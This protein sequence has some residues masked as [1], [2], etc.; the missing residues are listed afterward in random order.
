MDIIE[1]D[2]KSFQYGFTKAQYNGTVHIKTS[3]DHKL[4]L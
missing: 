3:P 4:N 2:P 1:T